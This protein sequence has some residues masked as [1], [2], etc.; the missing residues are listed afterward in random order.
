MMEIENENYKWV[1][2]EEIERLGHNEQG[3]CRI[4]EHTQYII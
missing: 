1:T 3:E 2:L 4:G